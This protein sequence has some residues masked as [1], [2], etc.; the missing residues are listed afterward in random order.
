MLSLKAL[1]PRSLSLKNLPASRFKNEVRFFFVF[2][3]VPEFLEGFLC[4]RVMGPS[5]THPLAGFNE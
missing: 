5:V 3:L 4:G 2:I 1:D